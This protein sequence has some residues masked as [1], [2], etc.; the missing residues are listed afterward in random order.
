MMKISRSEAVANWYSR[1]FPDAFI[2]A[3]ILTVIALILAIVFT[4]SSPLDVMQYWFDGIP[5]LF[6]FAFQLMFTYAAALVLVDTP[7]VQ[8]G[9]KKMAKLIKSPMAAYV[10]TSIVGALTSFIGWYIGPVVTAIFARAVGKEIKGVDYRLISAIAYSSFTISLT[11][12]SGSIPLLVA[13]EGKFTEMLGGIIT[14]EQTTFSMVNTV[15]AVAIV[16]VTTLIFIFIAKNKKE[17]VNFDDLA[18]HRDEVAAGLETAKEEVSTKKN[19]DDTFAT[20]VNSF[21]PIILSVGL[22]GFVFLCIYFYQKG[23]AGLNLNS[24]AVIALVLGF[25]VQKDAMAYAESFARNLVST[26]SI[27]MQFP[28]YGGIASVLAASGLAAQFT[29]MIVSASTQF[30][31]PV[32]VMIVSGILNMFVPSAGS[33]FTATAP[34]LIPAAQSLGVEMPRAVLAITYGDI[35]TNLIQP[36]WALLYFPIL[37]AGTRLSV[38]DFMGYCLPTFIAVGI[39]WALAL[40]FLP[41]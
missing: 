7:A 20:R 40:T 22:I 25:L 17:I 14:L 41:L 3:L 24:V 8:Q 34:F 5:W 2:F 31:Y 29:E 4:E 39:I 15:S 30:T 9:I 35:W 18:I 6:T 27:G 13:T 10:T 23:L 19:T 1:Y 33:Q 11:G 16:A 28:L 38:R 26:A 36:F 32:I 12:I 37:A 21:R